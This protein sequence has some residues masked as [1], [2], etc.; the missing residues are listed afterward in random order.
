M[1]GY[2]LEAVGHKELSD[3]KNNPKMKKKIEKKI[4]RCEELLKLYQEIPTGFFVASIIS[5]AIKN[6]QAVLLSGN[7]D[8]ETAK[9]CLKDLQEIKG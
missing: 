6:A 3:A 5:M 2:L 7:Y 4:V 9:K 1:A 8:I